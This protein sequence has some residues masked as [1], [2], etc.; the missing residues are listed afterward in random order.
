M[1]RAGCKAFLFNFFTF[2]Q[3]QQALDFH[4][5]PILI[6]NC[7]F[8]ETEP[9]KKTVKQR[10]VEFLVLD[11][12]RLEEVENRLAIKVR[13]LPCVKLF[14]IVQDVCD[15]AL[16]S[17]RVKEV[18]NSALHI[19]RLIPFLQNFIPL[20]KVLVALFG[21]VS[22]VIVLKELFKRSD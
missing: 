14:K 22:D 5:H 10:D 17:F 2:L 9:F 16:L 6:H 1:V 13:E 11:S 18:I 3:L 4:Q 15:F 19:K 12:V 7:V 20:V 8:G 21:D